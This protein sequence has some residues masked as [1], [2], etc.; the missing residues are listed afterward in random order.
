MK[1]SAKGEA[2]MAKMKKMQK[3]SLLLY[4]IAAMIFVFTGI[5][6]LPFMIR[7]G[8]AGIFVAADLVMEIKFYRCPHCG[9]G[10]DCRRRLLND[11]CCPQCKKYIFKDLG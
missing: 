3:L 8:L 11:T 4:A 6:N 10:L 2:L 7:I 9:K 1:I 5:Y